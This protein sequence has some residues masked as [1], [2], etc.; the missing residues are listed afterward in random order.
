[1]VVQPHVIGNGGGG[2]VVAA[3]KRPLLATTTAAAAA[4]Q[5]LGVRSRAIYSQVNHIFFFRFVLPSLRNNNCG[6]RS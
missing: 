1:L 3:G 2:V 6:A 5:S 4:Q